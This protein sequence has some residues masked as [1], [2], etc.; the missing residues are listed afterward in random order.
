M[1]WLIFILLCDMLRITSICDKFAKIVACLSQLL[2]NTTCV[3][4]L[5][6]SKEFCFDV[7]YL[8]YMLMIFTNS[9]T[10]VFIAFK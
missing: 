1:E 5:N 2:K 8:F 9:F 4:M 10:F 7:S 3:S 6:N